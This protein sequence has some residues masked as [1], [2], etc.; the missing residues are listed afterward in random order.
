MPV[1]T[2]EAAR[3]TSLFA[4]PRTARMAASLGVP[5]DN[6]LSPYQTHSADVA[7]IT[8][9]WA[10]PQRPRADALVTTRPDI[11]IAVTTADCGPILLADAS[12]CVVG[13]AHAGW[14]GAANGVVEA[15]IVAME[16]CGATRER[17][18]AAMGPMIRQSS[19]EVGPEFVCAFESQD[20]G[21]ERFFAPASRAGHALFDLASYIATRLAA[22]G[23]PP[24]RG[25]RS[26]HLFQPRSVLQLPALHP[27][28]GA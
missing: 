19:Y 15:T 16:Q 1:S 3:M 26:V 10:P 24:R 5:V 25:P 18:V 23:N 9:P 17:I 13:A 4:W 21:N 27:P 11:A 12:A 28:R 14:R 22:A 2:G 6:L 7:I 8:E 20:A